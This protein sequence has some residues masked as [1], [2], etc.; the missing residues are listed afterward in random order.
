M[1][2]FPHLTWTSG[3]SFTRRCWAF[4]LVVVDTTK[5]KED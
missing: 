2:A 5:I 1:W 4:K 3:V